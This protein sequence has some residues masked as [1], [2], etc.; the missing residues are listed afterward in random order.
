[1]LLCSRVYVMPLHFKSGLE[2]K[3]F[4]RS[5]HTAWSPFKI[6]E[7]SVRH[8]INAFPH[9]HLLQT[10]TIDTQKKTQR[11]L[12]AL[13]HIFTEKTA[14]IAEKTVN[15]PCKSQIFTEKAADIAENAV[16]TPCTITNIHRKSSTDS[17]RHSE[18]SLICHPYL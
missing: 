7:Q 11:V 3:L 10:F 6:A 1:M 15:H 14:E 9:S 16:F 4:K 13:P 18:S 17:R 8:Q 2:I 12:L 5:K